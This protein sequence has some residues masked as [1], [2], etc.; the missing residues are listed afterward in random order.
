MMYPVPRNLALAVG[1][2]ALFGCTA[3]EPTQQSKDDVRAYTGLDG[4][5][6]IVRSSSGSSREAG[7]AVGPDA[8]VPVLS[9][10]GAGAASADAAMHLAN[11]TLDAALIAPMSSVGDTGLRDAASPLALLEAGPPPP[12]AIT[13]R[14]KAVV[15]SMDLSCGQTYRAVGSNGTSA[16]AR[17]F[18]FF[19][20][21]LRLLNA[22][23]KDV[24]VQLA[25]RPPFQADGV[26][27]LDFE[28]GRDGCGGTAE[29]NTEITGT[30]PADDYRGIAFS[31]G[32]PES[33]QHGDP[34]SA[35]A[36]LRAAGMNVS[37]RDGYRFMRA[38]LVQSG[39]P[40]DMTGS[41]ELH[42]SS[43]GCTGNPDNGS[44]RCTKQNRVDVRLLGFDPDKNIIVADLGRLFAGVD[45]RAITVCHSEL[46]LCDPL[47]DRLGLD[48]ASG[49]P[50]GAQQLYRVGP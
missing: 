13:I 34:R 27:L 30:V 4:S 48:Y 23:G 41:V 29:V 24:P 38:E 3:S 12:R 33:L 1:L 31:N 47:F 49:E 22:A 9:D 37:Q 14:F 45:L 18:R 35:P 28:T 8:S 16:Y 44:A 25:N 21:D 2:L 10:S 11:D 50:S 5:V 42:V 26:S 46:E 40:P 15:G 19:V 32:V 20:E 17:D 6:P 43:A 7:P 36:P 39:A